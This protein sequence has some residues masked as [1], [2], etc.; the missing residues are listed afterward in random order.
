[1]G[2]VYPILLVLF[3]EEDWVSLMYTMYRSYS[4]KRT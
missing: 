3:W 2:Q 1:M 4:E